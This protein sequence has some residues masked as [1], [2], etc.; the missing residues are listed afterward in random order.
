MSNIISV[1]GNL[2]KDTTVAQAGKSQVIKLS[3]ADNYGYGKNRQTNF[4]NVSYFRNGE[5]QNIADMFSK[6]KS[7]H[8]TGEFQSRSYTDKNGVERISLDIRAHSVDFAGGANEGNAPAGGNNTPT[9]VP[10]QNSAPAPV[11]PA[12]VA[13][14]Q[15]ADDDGF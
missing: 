12:P 1:V 5:V 13:V 11:A 6:G 15:V 10:V 4:Y 7:V 9:R 8:I 2:T 3:L 14:A